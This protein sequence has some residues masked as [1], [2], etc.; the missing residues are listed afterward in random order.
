MRILKTIY[1]SALLMLAMG[2]FC[3]ELPESFQLSDDTTNDYVADSS[4][5][6]AQENKAVRES[7]AARIDPASEK[8]VKATRWIVDSSSAAPFGIEPSPLSG[9]EI[10]PLL[11][12]RRT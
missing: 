2:L 4:A 7:E 5:S 9:Q 12:I 1:L 10:L 6:A 11:S 3:G 8:R